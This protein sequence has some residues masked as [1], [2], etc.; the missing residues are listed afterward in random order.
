CARG[1]TSWTDC[2]FDFW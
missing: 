2:A 1:D